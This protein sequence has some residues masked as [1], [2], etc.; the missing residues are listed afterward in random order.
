MF[1][2]SLLGALGSAS[3]FESTSPLAGSSAG[4]D[5]ASLGLWPLPHSDTAS[6]NMTWAGESSTECPESGPMTPMQTPDPSSPDTFW[7]KG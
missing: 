1:V 3:V 2:L 6:A 7:K 4:T 5:V